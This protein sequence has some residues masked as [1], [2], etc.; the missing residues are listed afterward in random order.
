MACD[1]DFSRPY[2]CKAKATLDPKQLIVADYVLVPELRTKLLPRQGKDGCCGPL[3]DE[4]YW[5]T[6]T[7]RHD[8]S[9][10]NDFFVGKSCGRQFLDLISWPEVPPLFNPLRDLEPSQGRHVGPTGSGAAGS[11]PM[12]GWSALAKEAIAILKLILVALNEPAGPPLTR[13]LRSIQNNPEETDYRWPAGL[14]S[15]AEKMCRPTLEAKLREYA[16][17]QLRPY[18]FPLTQAWLERKDR[19]NPFGFTA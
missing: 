11:D 19:R 13:I 7:C 9:I 5:F 15:I 2:A 3:T 16:G 8:G 10:R 17:R 18:R 14:A 1:F 6:A 12:A 4:Y